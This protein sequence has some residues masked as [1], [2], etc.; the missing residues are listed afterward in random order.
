MAITDTLSGKA[1]AKFDFR[2][3]RLGGGGHSG[4]DS[5]Y[6]NPTVVFTNGS[7]ANQATGFFSS[8]FNVT[9][10][11]VTIGLGDADD[12]LGAA[13]DDKP[14][15]DPDGKD[16]RAIMIENL[17]DT[18]Y[19]T[20]TTGTNALVGWIGAGDTIIIKPGGTLFQ[21]FPVDGV[22]LDEAGSADEIKITANTATCSV[23]LSYVFG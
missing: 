18:N 15:E 3:A 4:E 9:T 13:G 7:G 19:V 14:T 12:P 20:V 8:T 6:S 17:D 16:L 10:T 5:L 2:L 1:S 23:K 21:S 11:G 22:T